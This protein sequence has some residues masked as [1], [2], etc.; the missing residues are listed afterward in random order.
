M[1]RRSLLFTLA[2]A[3]VAPDPDK[4]LW[5]PGAKLI[6]IP[7]SRSLLCS[8][9]LTAAI[10]QARLGHL[11]LNLRFLRMIE[12][13]YNDAWQRIEYKAWIES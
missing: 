10:V 3:L 1:T 7:P 4:L 9:E 11:R 5:R 2:A 6:S 8:P 13:Q 12:R